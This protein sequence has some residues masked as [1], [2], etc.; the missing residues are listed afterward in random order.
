MAKEKC[1]LIP[2]LTETDVKNLYDYITT[3]PGGGG[4]NRGGPNRPMKITGPVV[5]SGGAP[6][7]LLPRPVTGFFGRFGMNYGP[8]YPEG[9]ECTD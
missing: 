5:D 7:G 4:G 1:L 9:I 3:A 2:V 8:P 6:G